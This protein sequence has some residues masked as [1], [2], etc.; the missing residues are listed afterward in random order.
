MATNHRR[1]SS[2]KPSGLADKPEPDLR[3]EDDH[4]VRRLFGSRGRAQ[5]HC[6]VGKA[7]AWISPTISNVPAIHPNGE[8]R[9]LF[10][11]TISATGKP[12]FVTVIGRRVR[13]TSSRSF[14][15]V[16]LNFVAPIVRPAFV[17]VLIWSF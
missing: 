2:A 3:I 1:G 8:G 6:H 10:T 5:S 13:C 14:K 15:H 17:L 16:A 4:R 12:R 9:R 11:G 7:G